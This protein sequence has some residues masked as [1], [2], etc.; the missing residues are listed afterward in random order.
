MKELKFI[1]PFKKLCIT[2]GNLPTAYIESMS[3]YEGLTFLVNYLANN[4]IPAVNN[5]SEVVKELQDQFVIL[6]NYVDNYFENLDVQEEIN[7]KLDEMADEGTLAAIISEYLNSIALF[8]YDTVADLKLATNLIDGSYVRTLGYHTKNDGGKA[9][10]K[11][12]EITNDD[13]VDEAEI[14]ELYDNNLIAELIESEINVNMYGA[15]GDGINDDTTAIQ[16]AFNNSRGLNVSFIS[17]CTYLISSQ[18]KLEQHIIIRFNNALIKSTHQD[19]CIFISGETNKMQYIYDFNFDG[20]YLSTY[21][22]KVSDCRILKGYNINVKNCITADVYVFANTLTGRGSIFFDQVNIQNEISDVTDYNAVGNAIGIDIE[23]TDSQICNGNF[24]DCKISIKCKSSTLLSGIHAWNYY[25][26]LLKSGNIMV[27]VYGGLRMVGCYCDG[28][29]TM[30]KQ[31][32]QTQYSNIDI[33]SC[34][35]HYMIGDQTIDQFTP[36]PIIKGNDD[37]VNISNST[38][39]TYFYNGNYA[40]A[41]TFEGVFIDNTFFSKAY[42]EN[43]YKGTKSDDDIGTLTYERIK[44]V[45]YYS[46]TGIATNVSGASFTGNL[47]TWARPKNLTKV[48]LYGAATNGLSIGTDG[49]VYSVNATAW[50]SGNGTCPALYEINKTV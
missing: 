8:C 27:D 3:Y 20:N 46:F 9:L 1:S 45:V 11:V 33:D 26:E 29:P 6:K 13:V 32:T 30:V 49:S 43:F 31:N 34:I 40:I 10:Y 44:D 15:Y 42:Y 28:I 18:I 22:L 37:K 39:E 4:V 12:R 35:Y 5:N 50:A 25:D 7:N 16:K 14:I 41:N 21:G 38:F 19:G 47:P 48:V 23:N 2:I 24:K 17:N 36:V